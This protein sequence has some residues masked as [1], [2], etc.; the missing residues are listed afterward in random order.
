MSVLPIR[1]RLPHILIKINRQV[2]NR[3]LPHFLRISGMPKNQRHRIKADKCILNIL[4][5]MRFPQKNSG[6]KEAVGFNHLYTGHRILV[7]TM[8]I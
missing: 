7:S 1:C 5:D 3:K 6:S 8:T 4:N 2:G